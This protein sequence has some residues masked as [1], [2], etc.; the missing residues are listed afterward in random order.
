MLAR[1]PVVRE[2]R[3]LSYDQRLSARGAQ[4]ERDGG[5]LDCRAVKPGDEAHDAGEADA[6]AGP[7]TSQHAWRNVVGAE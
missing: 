5:E 7:K 6:F 2:S 4:R 3:G 1:W